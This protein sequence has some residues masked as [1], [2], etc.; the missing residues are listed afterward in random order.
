MNAAAIIAAARSQLGVPFRHQ[1]R[2]AGQYLDCAGLVM[3]VADRL[4]V[5]YEA[6][7]NYARTPHNRLIEGV[8]DNQPGLMRVSLNERQAGDILSMRIGREPQ[9]LGIFSGTTLIH[10]Y[11]AVGRVV[12]HD[13]SADWAARID[14]VYRFREV[15]P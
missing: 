4:G 11:E 13:L 10:C 9:H 5:A 12:E 2:L 7:Q 14:R 15:T 8:L 6:P 1:T 3:V